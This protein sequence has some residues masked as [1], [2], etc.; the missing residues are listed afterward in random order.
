MVLELVHF[1][2]K[3]SVTTMHTLSNIVSSVALCVK[4]HPSCEISGED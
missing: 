3:Y 2:V 1:I 4:T